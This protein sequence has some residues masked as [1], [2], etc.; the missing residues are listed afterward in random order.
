M[1]EATYTTIRILQAF[2]GIE[3]RDPLPWTENL[4]LTCCSLHGTKVGLTPS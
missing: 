1:T 2:K 4:T 3:S